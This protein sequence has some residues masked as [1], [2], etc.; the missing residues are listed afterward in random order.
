MKLK[1][2]Q[3]KR[4]IAAIVL[5]V[6]AFLIVFPPLVNGG[7]RVTLSPSAPV[8]ADRVYVTIGEISAHRIDISG[9]SAWQTISNKSTL[10]DLTVA[11]MSEMIAL[12]SLPL[13]Q[14]ETI[15]VKVTNATAVVNGTSQRVQLESSVFT[16]PAPFLIQFGTDTLIVLKVALEVQPTTDGVNLKLTFTGTPSS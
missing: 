1:P 5:L 13:G 12:G 3:A 4:I 15:R 10:V 6:V 8:N 9:P 14:Y 11:N 16:I 7:V 2:M